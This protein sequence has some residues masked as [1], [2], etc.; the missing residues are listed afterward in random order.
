MALEF[1][2]SGIEVL[3]LDACQPDTQAPRASIRHALK[4]TLDSRRYAGRCLPLS[5]MELAARRH[6]PDSGW[7][8]AADALAAYYPRALKLSESEA[9][10]VSHGRDLALARL[11]LIADLADSPFECQALDRY[12]APIELRRVHRRRLAAAANV[13]MV[14]NATVT[15]L[16]LNSAG[17]AVDTV[18]AQT[19]DHRRLVIRAK[20]VVLA[21][22]ALE[23]ARLLLASRDVQ[24]DG[25][26]N[27]HGNVGRYLLSP[28]KG[29][30]G[31]VH[32]RQPPVAIWRRERSSRFSRRPLSLNADTQN[33]LQLPAIAL[34]LRTLDTDDR[35]AAA[36]TRL[37]RSAAAQ[38]RYRIDWQA[39]QRPTPS[40]RV[41]LGGSHDA[42]GRPE[43]VIDWQTS[44]ADGESLRR[45]L[46]LFDEAL[47][48]C[49]AGSF[50]HDPAAASVTMAHTGI[51]DACLLGGARM[52]RDPRNSVVD[53]DG[54]VH[55]LV[56]L[57]VTGPAV[58]PTSG[59]DDP[60][61]TLTALALRLADHLKQ[62]EARARLPEVSLARAYARSEPATAAPRRSE[63]AA[64][65]LL[66]S[67]QPGG[68]A[69]GRSATSVR[70]SR[71]NTRG[72]R[73]R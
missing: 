35:I 27:G 5:D 56:N 38:H 33:R 60:M 45:S 55:G 12:N 16:G 7:P 34:R 13:C 43:W 57:Y 58:F 53:G 21:I 20:T 40:S 63:R 47:R 50:D 4:Q 49:G 31:M 61:L 24:R 69:A 6:L 67:D 36:L 9:S 30:L 52:G 39:E 22:G 3:V 15:G 65:A 18:I 51:P 72:P 25:I 64:A 23:T 66:E 70:R 32:L 44:L 68:S 42:Y 1:A 37:G 10:A 46:G 19:P 11:P 2:G 8:L 62:R 14:G 54:R 73:T 59:L 26:G 48:A 71:P 29:T 28:L 41:I 17:T